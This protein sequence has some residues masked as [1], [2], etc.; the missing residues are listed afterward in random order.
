[1]KVK[2]FALTLIVLFTAPDICAQK[3]SQDNSKIGLGLYGGINLQNLNGSDFWG[4]KLENDLILGFH[5]GLNYNLPVAPDF[6][7]QPGVIFN[8]KG[9]KK[10]VMNV[11]QK[12][13]NSIVTTIKLSYI[14]VPLSLLY[15]PQL[16]DGHILL[17]FGPYVAYGIAGNVKT[18][19]NGQTEETEV[20]FKNT[21]TSEDP[22]DVIFFRALDAGA[23]IFFGYEFY[24]GLFCQMEAQLGLLKVNPEYE[25][26]ANDK[27]SYKN[28]GFGLSVG[29]RF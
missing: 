3:R 7:F 29:Y 19:A 20:K 2:L 8:M 15:R 9:A 14:E 18:S 6:Y 5:G 4:E 22:S 17:G 27:T 28:T 10:D 13:D 24:F 16:G 11:P 21:V 12:A 1:M 25:L 23:N 26:L